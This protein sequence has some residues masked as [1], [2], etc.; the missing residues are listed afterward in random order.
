MPVCEA[1]AYTA[2]ED[3][4]DSGMCVYLYTEYCVHLIRNVCSAHKSSSVSEMPSL[5]L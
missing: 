2:H 1:A 5:I 3:G 4:A